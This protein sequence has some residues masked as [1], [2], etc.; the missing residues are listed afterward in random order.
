MFGVLVLADLTARIAIS[1]SPAR[2]VIRPLTL[3]EIVA[4]K[5]TDHSSKFLY[6][7][8][9]HGS[10]GIPKTKR[11][12]HSRCTGGGT[13]AS[14]RRKLLSISSRVALYGRAVMSFV[15]YAR[16]RESDDGRKAHHE[17]GHAVITRVLGIGVSYATLFSAHN[18]NS[19]T[20]G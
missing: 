13:W 16:V 2:E 15:D 4:I 11:S 19:A 10:F 5:P 12:P 8:L 18:G 17:A 20:T 3:A 1:R 14:R 7:G 6:H 9:M